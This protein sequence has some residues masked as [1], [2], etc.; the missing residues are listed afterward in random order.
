MEGA[1]TQVLALGAILGLGAALAWA[2]AVHP[3]AM[4]VW[5]PWDFSWLVFGGTC[6]GGWFYAL[7]LWRAP[8]PERPAIPRRVTYFAGV[9]LIYVVLQTRFEYLALHMFFLNRVQHL[10]MHHLGPF[11]VAW[12]WPGETLERGSPSALVRVGRSRPVQQMLN[13][14][15]QPVIAAVLFAGLILLWLTPPVHVRAML[16]PVLYTVMNASMVIDGLLFWFL[17]LDHRDRPLARLS[18]ASRL[19]LVMAVQV[20]QIMAGAAVAMAATDLYPS[21]ALCGRIYTGVSAV[22]DQQIGGFV[23]YFLGAMMSVVA[24]L[25]LFR[26]LWRSEAEAELRTPAFAGAGIHTEN[27][28]SLAKSR[29]V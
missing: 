13:V 23:V 2:S 27:P 29:E 3:A 28:E 10:V 18:Y 11:L 24:A 7:G 8:K 16:D 12:A 5:G 19:V 6:L 1:R 9:A 26:R 14:V 20:P 21:Y 22:F 15:Q 4:P 17:V 25:I